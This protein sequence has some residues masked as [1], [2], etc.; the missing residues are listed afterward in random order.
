MLVT[1]DGSDADVQDIAASFGLQ[2]RSQRLSTLL[3]AT[4]VRFGIP[5]G[6][7]VGTVLA[8]LAA[9]PRA[10]ARVPNHV[11][12]LQ[13]AGAIV[14]YAFKRIS[15]DSDDANGTDVSVAVIDT[16]VD[17]THPALAGVIAEEYDAMPD[18][19][20]VRTATTAPRSP[21]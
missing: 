21:V 15:L 12:D 11:Y 2:V 16:A 13:Q 20:Q 18:I 17:P 4:I 3:G 10:L 9:D 8:Q 7:P 5:D 6:R 1:V 14:N 19:A